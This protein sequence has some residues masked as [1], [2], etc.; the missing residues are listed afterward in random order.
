[1][2][3]PLALEYTFQKEDSV[4]S[5]PEDHPHITDA[6]LMGTMP[7]CDEAIRQIR[8]ELGELVGSRITFESGTDGHHQYG[9]LRFTSNGATL[10]RTDYTNRSGGVCSVYPAMKMTDS[11]K[12]SQNEILGFIRAVRRF[13]KAHPN[14]EK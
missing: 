10:T 9:Q 6:D 1:M 12:V 7:E 14:A 3:H 13:V 5:T 8:E 4:Q 11:N 2:T